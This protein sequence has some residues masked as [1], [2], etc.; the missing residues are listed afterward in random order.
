MTKAEAEGQGTEA[1]ESPAAD[2]TPSVVAP[3]A[4][5]TPKRKPRHR[6]KPRVGGGF[7]LIV[8]TLMLV[9]GGLAIAA[10]GGVMLRLPV[11]MV[12]EVETRMNRAVDP[13]LPEGAVSVGGIAVG[14]HEGWQPVV[15]LS[16]LRLLQRGGAALLILPETEIT[17]DLSALMAREVRPS[18]V[19]LQGGDI[20][21]KRGLD[22]QFDIA[23]GQMKAG[24]AIRS[25][26]SFRGTGSCLRPAGLGQAYDH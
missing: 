19:H 1:G 4:S 23:L 11:W 12:A 15:R 9:L 24:P 20:T 25:L 3:A 17:L 14:L 7:G 2:P 21:V 16:D 22:G 18:R 8:L 26:P 10:A 5:A 13:A 6:R